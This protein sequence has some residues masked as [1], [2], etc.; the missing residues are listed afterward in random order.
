MLPVACRVFSS[1]ELVGL[2]LFHV[3]KGRELACLALVAKLWSWEAARHLWDTCTQLL[4][5]EHKV[6]ATRHERVASLIHHLRLD[7]VVQLWSGTSPEMPKLANLRTLTMNAALSSAPF[8]SPNMSCLLPTS[9]QELR[10]TNDNFLRRSFNLHVRD[11]RPSSAS[12]LFSLHRTCPNLRSLSLDIRLTPRACTAVEL[13]LLSSSLQKLTI[14]TLTSEN[15][16]DWSIATILAQ[17]TLQVLEL[18][19]SITPE[20]L[21]I[22]REQCDGLPTLEHLQRLTVNFDMGAEKAMVP[23]FAC[24]PNLTTL[25][26]TLSHTPDGT[27]W[28]PD[29]QVFLAMSQL[30]HLHTLHIRISTSIERD[31]HGELRCTSI[32][33]ADFKAISHLPLKTLTIQPV[34]VKAKHILWLREVTYQD[35]LRMLERWQSIDVVYLNMV[36]EEVV[37]DAEQEEQIRDLLANMPFGLFSVYEYVRDDATLDP[38]IWLGSNANFCPDPREWVPRRLYEPGA[39]LHWVSDDLEKVEDDLLVRNNGL[40]LD[41]VPSTISSVNTHDSES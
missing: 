33:G 9:L 19:C 7:P 1:P 25:D 18:D 11:L 12:W 4:H 8:E 2:I 31:L 10:L 5:L 16:D 26:V 21:E 6:H 20:S 38:E 40:E 34:H 17:T 29:A 32:T 35:F 28:S 23:L 37:C 14:G 30:K 24:T 15:F 41:V 13:F 39:E 27:P 22:L 3:D 36:C